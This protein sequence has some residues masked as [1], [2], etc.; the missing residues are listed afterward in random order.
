[1]RLPS[2]ER[3]RYAALGMQ[4]RYV[5]N[6]GVVGLLS[7]GALALSCS[8]PTDNR[9]TGQGAWT[10]SDGAGE[11][12]TGDKQDADTSASGSPTTSTT[13]PGTSTSGTQGPGEDSGSEGTATNG[14]QP[15]HFSAAGDF[16][17]ND[18]TDEN[19]AQ[20]N[21][22]IVLIL[23]DF[24]YDGNAEEWWTEN[25][26]ALND[27]NV[28]GA[29]GNHDEPFDDFVALWPLNGGKW[30]FIHKV[31]NVA[32]VAYDTEE[33]DPST[34]E[35][36]LAEAQADPEVDHI[37]PFSHKTVFTP[38][39]ND[40]SPDADEGYFDVFK[41]FDKIPMVLGGHNHFY[42]RM[43]P[44]PGTDF[45]WVTVGNG[46]ANPHD[47]EGEDNSPPQQFVRTNGALHCDVDDQTISC[48]MISNE[49]TVW[50]EFIITPGMP[51]ESDQDPAQAPGID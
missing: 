11:S 44:A 9:L 18:V 19:M 37:I 6:W 17:D 36:I 13:A 39:A 48:E 42:A 5:I 15:F 1:M 21:P 33:N 46:G 10:A 32:F 16:R 3:S 27:L 49:G 38:T 35:P 12:S 47:D 8:G 31:S 51:P 20:H 30:E 7:A 2:I 41:Q 4:K 14:P 50:D 23:G 28:I 22:D 29:V 25:M 45:I 40:L 43:N 24:S 26:D 34:I